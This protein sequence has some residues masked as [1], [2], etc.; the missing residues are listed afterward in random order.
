MGLS[1]PFKFKITT[2]LLQSKYGVHCIFVKKRLYFLK[3]VIRD[4]LGDF[5]IHVGKNP[6]PL[7]YSSIVMTDTAC[8]LSERE[9]RSD[10]YMPKTFKG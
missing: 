8:L 4:C 6:R 9:L 2:L 1:W 7:N 5:P 3:K 10:P